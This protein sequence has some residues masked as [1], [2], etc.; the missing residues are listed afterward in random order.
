MQ[1]VRPFILHFSFSI[2]HFPFSEF[3]L[4][5]PLYGLN[6]RILR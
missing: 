4:T 3:V 1:N 2:S 6:S 5:S